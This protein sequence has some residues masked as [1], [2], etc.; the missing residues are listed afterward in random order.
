MK[1][2][3]IIKGELP[4]MKGEWR[5]LI[6]TTYECPI[7]MLEA[8]IPNDVELDL[9]DGKA[10]LSM[11]AFTFNN[12]K[13]FGIKAFFHQ[14]FG[15][16]NFRCYVKS[17]KD[18]TKGVVFIKELAAKRIMAFIANKIYNEPFYYFPISRCKNKDSNNKMTTIAYNFEIDGVKEEVYVSK[19]K[20]YRFA[21]KDSLENFVVDRYYAFVKRKTFGSRI[22]TIKHQP[23]KL[24]PMKEFFIS[25]K[26]HQMMP[27]VFANYLSNPLSV[28]LV[29]GSKI[30]VFR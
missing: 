3:K 11:V 7:N 28:Y 1:I 27:P 23:W 22:Y 24:I 30:E 15:E 16:I 9:W 12:A 21:I 17:K 29:D 20:K 25:P 5:D 26:I 6:I 19:T 8:Y 4:F 13:M 2:T 10:L 18:N 14:Y